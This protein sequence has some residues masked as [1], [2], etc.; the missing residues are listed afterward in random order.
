MNKP[1][2]LIVD[3]EMQVLNAV[4]RD[5]RQHYHADYRIVKAGS[6][7]EALDAVHQLKLR[8]NPLALFLVDQRMPSMTGTEFLREAIKIYPDARK[9]LLTAYADTQAAI[10]SGLARRLR[11]NVQ[12][13]AVKGTRTI[14]KSHMVRN[15][16]CPEIKVDAE[17]Y[18]V[19]VNGE[20][21]TCRPARV[22]PLAQ[23]YFLR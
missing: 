21:V 9:V 6:G 5:L 14:S 4:E 7:A 13:Y 23:R 3:D 17:T 8:G 19:Y 20:Q 22:L 2:L 16:L 15:D 1:V 11:S 18:R 12:L 10:D